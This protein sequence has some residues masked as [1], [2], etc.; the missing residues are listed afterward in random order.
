MF[1]Y[2]T[3]MQNI[4]SADSIPANAYFKVVP[5]KSVGLDNQ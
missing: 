5:L 3:L 2:V 1:H 4:A